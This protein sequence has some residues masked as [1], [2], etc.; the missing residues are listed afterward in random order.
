MS[1]FLACSVQLSASV[2][3]VC[4]SDRVRRHAVAGLRRFARSPVNFHADDGSGYRWF[5]DSVLKVVIG[6]EQ[7]T[8]QAA[9]S[10]LTLWAHC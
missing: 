7:L 2:E 4:L 5:A 3:H 6:S 1:P 10:M 9:M 8:L